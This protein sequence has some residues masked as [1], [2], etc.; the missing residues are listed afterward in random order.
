[1]QNTSI[2]NKLFAVVSHLKAK[3]FA[4]ATKYAEYLHKEKLDAFEVPT[5]GKQKKYCGPGTIRKT[6]SVAA[7]LGLIDN[8][9]FE[10]TSEGSAA[11]KSVNNFRSILGAQI[12]GY[13]DDNKFG[14][15]QVLDT[16]DSLE[17]PDLPDAT[18][19]FENGKTKET[20][21]DEQEFRK[22]LYL[23]YLCEKL[24]REIKHLYFRKS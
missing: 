13:L 3:T 7:K 12:L 17:P 8:N 23:L 10:L 11:A 5:K 18:T 1:M 14:I 9:S 22:L 4:N 16:I 19:I 21:I 15:Q 2:Y 20:K 24:D 6:I